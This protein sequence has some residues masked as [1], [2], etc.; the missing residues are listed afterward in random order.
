MIELWVDI[1]GWIG[2]FLILLAYYLVSSKKVQSDKSV[3]Q[4]MNLVGAIG[5]GINAFHREAFP[6][7]T[8]EIVWGT[9]AIVTLIKLRYN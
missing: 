9:I 7:F 4:L 2:A 3:Y 6:S 8:L 5:I 1:V